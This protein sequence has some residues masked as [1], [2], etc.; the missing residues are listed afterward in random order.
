MPNRMTVDRDEN[1]HIYYQY[2]WSKGIR[3]ADYEGDDRESSLPTEVM[4]I[5]GLG[6]DG[7]VGYSPIAMAKEQHRTLDGL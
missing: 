1:G 2:L 3:C 7:L 5:P 4:Q 6:F